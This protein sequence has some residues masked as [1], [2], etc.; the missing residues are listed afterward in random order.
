MLTRLIVFRRE[1]DDSSQIFIPFI[2][3]VRVGCP[4]SSSSA[5]VDLEESNISMSGSP[6]S[7][8]PPTLP[9]PPPGKLTPPSSPNVGQPTREGWEPVELQLDYWSKQT[10]GE[11]GK[12][13]L[14]Q[15]FR[16]L[17]VQRL[18]A[19]GETP[20]SHLSM[21]YTT[22]E[23]KQKSKDDE[24]FFY[25][26]SNKF[27]ICYL[28]KFSL[29]LMLQICFYSNEIRQKEGKG[30]R[31]RAKKSDCGWRDASYMFC[32]NSQHSIKR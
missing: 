29:I 22:K 26:Y 25:H 27:L 4:E 15:A 14:R 17:H 10:Q 18:P 11:K 13:T 5:S 19:L 1:T 16:A 24:I 8:P 31:K 9:L 12:S 2:N 21:N 20:G 28:W 30:E 32:E 6:P 7:L 23:K 3:D